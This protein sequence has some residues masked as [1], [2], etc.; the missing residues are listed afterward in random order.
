[1]SCFANM[2]AA[3]AVRP[4]LVGRR[5]ST[6]AI[7]PKQS[8]RTTAAGQRRVAIVRVQAEAQAPEKTEKATARQSGLAFMLD[9][10]TRKSHSMAENSA[11]VSG[12]FRRVSSIYGRWSGR[13]SV[14]SGIDCMHRRVVPIERSPIRRWLTHRSNIVLVLFAH[15]RG[16]ASKDQFAQMVASLY[17]VY[18]YVWPAGKNNDRRHDMR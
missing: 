8:S 10:G 13:S 14:V 11:F 6:A 15:T 3:S 7:F 18:R 5:A 2:T 9:D 12:F 17:F 16:I 1:M 4:P